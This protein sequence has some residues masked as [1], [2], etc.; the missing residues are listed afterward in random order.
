VQAA[1]LDVGLSRSELAESVA[2][3][4]RTQCASGAIP[5]FTGGKVDPWDHV[6][7][8]MA[9]D[10]GGEHD[11]AGRA[12]AWLATVQRPDGGFAAAHLDGTP[13][14]GTA[15]SHHAAYVAVGVWHHWLATGDLAAVERLWPVV[16][17]GIEF[18]LA[19]RS[20][21]GLPWWAVDARGAPD[22]VA[23]VT[24]TASTLHG[25]RCALQLADLMQTRRPDWVAAASLLIEAL[26]AQDQNP[27]AATE[28]TEKR[29]FSMDWYYPVL[30]GA[31]TGTAGR[32]RLA[33]RWDDFVVPGRGA[34]C[35][36]DHP[37]VTGAETCELA[38]AVNALGDRQI[39]AQLV[40]DTTH[41]RDDD[42]S[43]WTGLVLTDGVR[44]P[45][46][47]STWTAAAVVLA[48]DAIRAEHPRS[49]IYPGPATG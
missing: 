8:A 22:R 12:Y 23:L 48:V 40:R 2:W 18:A 25:L 7:A 6:E 37:W 32:R 36:D 17:A 42:G 44:W 28:F 19:H 35:V 1:A 21:S 38:M 33:A 45:V 24:G 5:W 43:W 27:S 4:A 14:T 26:V 39:A 30:V 31:V 10:V 46:E 20:P 9:L 15:E 41:L 49:G 13:T 11:L 16:R 34:R 29:R 3:I 47:R